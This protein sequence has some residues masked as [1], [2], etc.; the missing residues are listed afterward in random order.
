[1]SR[2]FRWPRKLSL[3]LILAIV[4]S[5]VP[6][7][8]FKITL[9]TVRAAQNNACDLYPIALAATT[10]AG[11]APGAMLNDIYNG[12]G[13]GNFGWLTWAGSTSER[14]LVT[15]LTAP[16]DVDTYVNPDD[17]TDHV[18]ATGDWVEGKPGVSNSSSVRAALDGLEQIDVAVPVWDTATGSGNNI[19]Y[20]VSG[21]ALVRLVSYQLNQQNRISARYLGPLTCGQIIQPPTP[22]PTPSP[23]PTPTPSPL[24]GATLAL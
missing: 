2:T 15:S 18:L 3:L 12:T 4:C 1:M 19:R 8:L 11:L 23:T 16:G 14:T 13:A 9:P 6:L 5:T 22:T 21:F 10:L 20:H 24:S 17:P 7:Q